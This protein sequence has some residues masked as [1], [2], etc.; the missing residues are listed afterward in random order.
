M[1]HDFSQSN[2]NRGRERQKTSEVLRRTL[3]D[4]HEV[5]A[6]AKT[7]GAKQEILKVYSRLNSYLAS[8]VKFSPYIIISQSEHTNII[9]I[10]KPSQQDH[11]KRSGYSAEEHD[12]SGDHGHNVVEQKSFFPKIKTNPTTQTISTSYYLPSVLNTLLPTVFI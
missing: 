12:K 4:V 7:C 3:P 11:L 6:Q 8:K 10:E 5:H 9:S 1:T 2:E